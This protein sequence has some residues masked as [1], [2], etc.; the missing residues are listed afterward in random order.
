MCNFG[1]LFALAIVT[2]YNRRENDICPQKGKTACN[3]SKINNKSTLVMA[4]NEEK[5]PNLRDEE[6]D[7]LARVKVLEFMVQGIVQFLRN[8]FGKNVLSLSSHFK[9]ETLSPDAKSALEFP[10]EKK[11]CFEDC[12]YDLY[13]QVRNSKVLDA[14]FRALRACTDQN[15]MFAEI[16]KLGEVCPR[17]S[18][19]PLLR[20]Q[21]GLDKLYS[22]LD[23]PV[24]PT[25][26]NKGKLVYKVR[27]YLD[28]LKASIPHHT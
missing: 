24:T 25:I 28:T 16:K 21:S 27:R 23:A 1:P 9:D 17:I 15:G 6:K 12:W 22:L 3:L 8:V 10:D 5:G 4:E 20:S 11:A 14:F 13:S 26:I 19:S 7:L 18:E 2:R